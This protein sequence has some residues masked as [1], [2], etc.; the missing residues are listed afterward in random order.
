MAT[1][2]VAM[3]QGG[4]DAVGQ[5]G[6]QGKVLKVFHFFPSSLESSPQR[7]T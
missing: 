5:G 7:F 2:L 4:E 1:P 3:E 6:S